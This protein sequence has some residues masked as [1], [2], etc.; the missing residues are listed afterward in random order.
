MRKLKTIIGKNIV[1]KEVVMQ[2]NDEYYISDKIDKI[3]FGQVREMLKD[4]FWSKDISAEE[5]KRGASNSALVVAAYHKNNDIVGYLRVISDKTRFAYLLDVYVHKK[6]RK[7]GIARSMVSFALNHRELKDVYQWLLVTRDAHDVYKT[8]GF[9]P[10]Q[11]TDK[12]MSIIKP[13][14]DR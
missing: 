8:V 5:I 12:W 7:K 6:H 11:H 13:R 1:E 9:Q 2:I 10:L 14:P 3:N 4:A